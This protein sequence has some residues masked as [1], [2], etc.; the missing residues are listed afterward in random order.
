[1]DRNRGRVVHLQEDMSAADGMVQVKRFVGRC[2]VGGCSKEGCDMGK[3]YED[4]GADARKKVWNHLRWSPQH[5]GQFPSDEE[6]DDLLDA[7]EDAWLKVSTQEWNQEDFD[8]LMA[9]RDGQDNSD[10]QASRSVP[11]PD[12]TPKSKGKGKQGKEGKGGKGKSKGKGSPNLENRLES[13]IRKQTENMLHFSRAAGTC[14][15]ALRVASD[16]CSQAATTFDKQREAMEEGMEEMIVAFGID[17]P[18]RQRRQNLELGSGAS[19]NID[20]AKRVRRGAPY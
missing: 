4:G 14:I 18:R 19:T 2:P 9:E 1:M 17:P 15:S 8:Q 13:Q 20:L 10:E 12:G 5:G 11:E 7:D 16:M 3:G 6:V